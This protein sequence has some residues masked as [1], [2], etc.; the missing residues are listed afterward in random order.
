MKAYSGI[1]FCFAVFLLFVLVFVP[2]CSAA[3]VEEAGGALNKA[4]VD[5]NSAYS[6]VAEAADSGA[7]VTVLLL[8]LSSAGNYLSEADVAYRVGNYN[9]AFSNAV[10]CSNELQGVTDTALQLLVSAED[11]HS[12]R[13][14]WTGIGSG[15]GLVLLG[16]FG[17]LVWRLMSRR[18]FKRVLGLKPVVEDQ[19]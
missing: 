8:K 1:V 10:A 16:V 15:V 4:E 14:L 17:F 13:V 11:A 9:N 5:L 12:E 18:Y 2:V 19:Q 6:A 3:T 7:N